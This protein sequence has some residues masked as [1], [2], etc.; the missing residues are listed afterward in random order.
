MKIG[1]VHFRRKT[2]KTIRATAPQLHAVTVEGRPAVILSPLDLTG[3]LLGTES[4]TM[5]GYMPD[6][7]YELLRN[8]VVQSS[9]ESVTP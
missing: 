5:H 1:K 6:S 2:K 4:Y 3:G 9:N 8:I 7:A